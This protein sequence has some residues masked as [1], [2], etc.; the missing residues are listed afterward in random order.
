MG[1][2]IC[3]TSC[4]R[5][6]VTR[7]RSQPVLQRLAL[8]PN[9]AIS[10]R[11]STCAVPAEV[12]VLK[13]MRLQN[14][15]WLS[16]ISRHLWQ[17]WETRS[18]ARRSGLPPVMS[19]SNLPGKNGNENMISRTSGGKREMGTSTFRPSLKA[20][21]DFS[22]FLDFLSTTCRGSTGE[23]RMLESIR[24]CELMMMTFRSKDSY[25]SG[26]RSGS[27]HM[28]SLTHIAGR[29]SLP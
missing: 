23:S 1:C 19:R 24:Q 5:K 13:L 10:D 17:T 9:G 29:L 20:R 18:H 25:A 2:T 12:R 21:A 28:I 14:R 8:S 11:D 26:R 7:V 4:F 15:G 22:S 3:A 27:D 16:A 6:A